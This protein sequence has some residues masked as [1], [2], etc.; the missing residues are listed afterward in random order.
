MAGPS[1]VCA[2]GDE[3]A[4]PGTFAPLESAGMGL[5][6]DNRSEMRDT[7]CETRDGPL[8]RLTIP[9]AFRTDCQSALRRRATARRT[10][11]IKAK[12]SE[13]ELI[14]RHP[15][16]RCIAWEAEIQGDLKQIKPN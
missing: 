5:F 11:Q 2:R 9:N 15:P 7:R 12:Q 1:R 14:R 13:P 16:K 6:F 4:R 10:S 8:C 3:F